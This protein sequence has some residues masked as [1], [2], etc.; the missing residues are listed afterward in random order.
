MEEKHRRVVSSKGNASQ[1]TPTDIMHTRFSLFTAA[2]AS[3]VAASPT[4]PRQTSSY[5]GYLI[6][7]FSDAIPEVQ[8]HLSDGTSATSFSFLNGGGPVLASSV[9]TKAV[10]DIFLATNSAR[11]E[12]Y[13]LAT[14]ESLE[15]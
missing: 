10:R 12:Y 3:V 11:S 6:S 15:L 5:V 8:F 14:G 4:A 2:L 13:L 1:N 9:G 7:T